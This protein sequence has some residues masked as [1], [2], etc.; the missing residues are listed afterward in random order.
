MDTFYAETGMGCCIRE[1]AS[2]SEAEDIIRREIGIYNDIRVLRKATNEDID[3]ILK[4]GGCIPEHVA[5]KK[6]VQRAYYESQ[7]IY[8]PD[9]DI[10]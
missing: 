10:S 1:A 7:S 9:I 3:S 2:I 8:N 5:A 6:R 4:K